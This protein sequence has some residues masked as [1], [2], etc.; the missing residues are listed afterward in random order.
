M[1][2]QSIIEGCKKGNPTF[3][4]KLLEKYAGYLKVVI[5]RYCYDASLI[6]DIL[7][8]SWISIFQNINS[9][10]EVG[11]FRGW[12]SK[13]AIS[14]CYKTFKKRNLINYVDHIPDERTLSPKAIESLDYQDLMNVVLGLK[15]PEREVFLMFVID[16]LNHK[17]IGSLLGFDESTSRVYLSKA[18]KQLRSQLNYLKPICSK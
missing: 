10:R 16:D 6:N 12:M 11:K 14:Q 8:E 1:N 2:D 7:Q 13:I 4:K 3:Q 15:S 17:E 18:R 9:Y 5:S